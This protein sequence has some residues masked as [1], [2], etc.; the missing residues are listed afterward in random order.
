MRPCPRP[1]ITVADGRIWELEVR[2]QPVRARMCGFGDKVSAVGIDVNDIDLS[3]G[4]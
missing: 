4:S 3:V 2:Q 1:L